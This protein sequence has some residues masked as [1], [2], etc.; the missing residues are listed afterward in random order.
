MILRLYRELIK[1][2]FNNKIRKFYFSN[3]RLIWYTCKDA[4]ERLLNRFSLSIECAIRFDGPKEDILATLPLVTWNNLINFPLG[5]EINPPKLHF[6]WPSSRPERKK[7]GKKD[8]ERFKET[9][10]QHLSP[11]SRV[12]KIGSVT[13]F[14]LVVIRRRAPGH[15]DSILWI[16][17]RIFNHLKPIQRRWKGYR[18]IGLYRENKVW[19]IER[20]KSY[21]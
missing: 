4:G 9:R 18:N 12:G 21:Q 1:W 19:I 20:M 8:I 10:L 2:P 3:Y 7:I 17:F 16:L 13:W 5:N 14:N 15:K 11:K 6:K